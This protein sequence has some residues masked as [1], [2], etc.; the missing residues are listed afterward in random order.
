MPAAVNAEL[1]GRASAVGRLGLGAGLVV[2][3][4]L[5]TRAWIGAD[6]ARPGSQVLS[7]ALGVRDL[8]IGAGTLTA[9]P[10][11]RRR[12]LMAALAADATDLTVT[13]AAGERLPLR[14]RVI[15]ALAAGAGIAMGAAAL[16][17][18]PAPAG[19]EPTWPPAGPEP[20]SPPPG[21]PPAAPAAAG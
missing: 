9:P 8:V 4:R 15:V 2:V 18:R 7:R 12:W 11:E 19:T 6:S 21:P 1:L 16:A 5:L 10:P 13:L 14:G 17:G 3:P 20:T